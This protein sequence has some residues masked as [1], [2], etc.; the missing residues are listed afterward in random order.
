[1]AVVA[2]NPREDGRYSFGRQGQGNCEYGPVF[3]AA[4]RSGLP[5]HR[6]T[7]RPRG[8]RSFCA[9]SCGWECGARRFIPIRSACLASGRRTCAVCRGASRCGDRSQYRSKARRQ[10]RAREERSPAH[11]VHD[12]RAAGQAGQTAARVCDPQRHRERSGREGQPAAADFRGA[13]SRRIAWQSRRR[14]RPSQR[15]SRRR[16]RH[17]HRAAGPAVL[18]PLLPIPFHDDRRAQP[19]SGARRHQ[20]PSWGRR[21]AWR[22]ADRDRYCAADVHLLLQGSRRQAGICHGLFLRCVYRQD[23]RRKEI[24][25]QDRPDRGNGCRSRID[26]GDTGVSGDVSGTYACALGVLDPPGA[27]LCR[28]GLGLDRRKS[29]VPPRCRIPDRVAASIGCRPRGGAHRGCSCGPAGHPF[30]ADGHAGNLGSAHGGVRAAPDRARSSDH[31]TFHD[32]RT[33]KGQ[34]G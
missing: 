20:G 33:G 13:D 27:L 22:S 2:R 34:I 32:D 11:A 17:P 29:R 4:D 25:R 1:M 26:I 12:R 31:Q 30:R 14:A 7:P 24:S 5:V 10:F 16:R 9:G 21:Y 6:Q 28:P 3:R 15:E 8:R 18:R 19:E 23:R